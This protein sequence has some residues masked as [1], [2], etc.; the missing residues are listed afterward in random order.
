MEIVSGTIKKKIQVISHLALER[1]KE[2]QQDS[3]W[4]SQL[5]GALRKPNKQVRGSREIVP[6]RVIQIW[7]FS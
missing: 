7:K 5:E 3:L 2:G 1:G 4:K 6:R